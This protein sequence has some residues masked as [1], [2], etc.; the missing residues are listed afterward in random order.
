[1]RRR[2]GRRVRVG[3]APPP[4]SRGYMVS[5]PGGIGMTSFDQLVPGRL[6]FADPNPPNEP[7]PDNGL[8]MADDVEGT[9]KWLHVGGITDA[10]AR[11]LALR[12][13]RTYV[14]GSLGVGTTAPA[15][16]LSVVAPGAN[17]IV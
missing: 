1:R 9:T 2:A 4:P 10:G 8:G 17:E 14:S 6:R 16:R 3:G 5:T 12:A 11:R 7:Y 13:D 15:A